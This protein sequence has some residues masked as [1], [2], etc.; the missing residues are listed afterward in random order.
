MSQIITIGKGNFALN[1]R[2]PKL[3]MP[4]IVSFGTDA[5]APDALFGIE[6][7]SR[8]NGMDVAVPSSVLLPTGDMGFFG[9]PAITGHRNGRDFTLQFGSWA[10]E[11]SGNKTILHGLDT[12]AKINLSITLTEHAS[13]LLSMSTA[14]T[15]RGEAGYH[16][17]RCM[18]ATFAV[19]AGET[20]LTS[21]TGMWGREFQT[22]QE[23]LGNGVWSQE[24]RR[25]RTSHDR[26]PMIFLEN[27]GKRFGVTL[28]WSGNHQIA[29]DRT[30]DGQRL[31]HI[32]E[33]FEPGEVILGN[34]ETYQS[35]VAY[36]GPHTE[37]FH[38]FVRSELLDWPDG[39]MSPRPVTLN[40]WEGNYF[41]HK[42][43]SL[44]AQATAAA[45]IGIERFVL[46]DGWFGKR[47]DDTT[48]LGDWDIDARKYPD[49]L[50]PLVDH[51]TGLGMQFGIWFEPEMISPVSELF[52][53]HPDWA[54]QIDGRP[55][56]QSRTQ[57]VLDL[58]RKEVSDYLFSK[59]DAVLAN[60]AVSY[61]KWDMNR[62]LTHAGG[63]DGRAKTS[64]QTRAVYALMDRVRAA[65]PTVE[66]ESCASGG[67]RIDFGALKRTHRVWTSDC[68][69]ALE[70]LEIQRGASLFVPPEILGSHISASPNHQ[71]GRR[72]TLA[73]RALVAMAYHMGVELN[74]LELTTV[75][76]AELKLYI[77]TYKRLRGLLHAPVA[78]FRMEPV[79]GRYV[80]G[81][82]S[83]DK[84]VVIVAQGPQ[85]VGEQ[86]A[87]L[88]L[89]ESITK[90]GGTWTITNT[91]PAK[92][93]FI[94]IS[95][96][97]K[98]LLS[99]NISFE[100]S[101]VGLAGL[102]LPML[103]PESALL[104]E[105]EPAKGGKTNG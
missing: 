48:S 28:G 3:G 74:P 53:K 56:L 13:G 95:E 96:G 82:A 35:P 76:R 60:H 91:L 51:V 104:L 10:V 31:I 77:E 43:V 68:T 55:L 46:D 67:G 62:D 20:E 71:T 44:K 78:N 27:S 58:T 84:I 16:L 69:D 25:G 93:E 66:I 102:P 70:R 42:M 52:K 94:R 45:E 40:T 79:D 98:K 39:K 9:W 15:N 32:G 7:S 21:F 61:I 75:E 23:L 89:P 4:E 24:S 88:K 36:A 92:P 64:A 1:L 12:V 105:L 72:H 81:A 63:A 90:L 22:R 19:P 86:P 85:M 57:L 59:I 17:N 87:P 5:T 73:F 30:D 49:G 80:W 11:S 18:A 47:D 65:H 26:F 6:R 100:L 38:A 29:I 37:A 54:L 83:K 50:K 101:S 99:G 34:G 8:V 97:Q 33:L 41:D 2:L 14:L 103:K